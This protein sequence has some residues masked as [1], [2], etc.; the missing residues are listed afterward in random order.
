MFRAMFRG[1]RRGFLPVC[2]FLIL[3]LIPALLFARA[4]GGQGYSGGGGGG[5]SGGGGGSGSGRGDGGGLL[6]IVFELFRLCIAYPAIGIPIVLLIAGFFA[7]AYFKGKAGYQTSVIR[8]ANASGDV[9]RQPAIVTALQQSD[10]A[11]SPDTFLS[12]VTSAFV[13]IQ[14]AWSMQKLDDVRPFLS[15]AV[16]ERFS[17]QFDEQRALG[18]RNLMDRVTITSATLTHAQTD[19]HFDELAVRIVATAI[20]QTIDAKNGRVITGSTS[21]EPFVE[22]WSFLRRRGAKTQPGKPGLMEGQC[23]N[24]GGAIALN[25]SANC[26]YCRALL[27][28]GQYDWVL[29]EITQECEW[30]PS[31]RGDLPGVAALRQRDPEFNPQ[32]MED[33]A[34][35]IFWRRAAAERLQSADPLRKVAFDAFCQHFSEQ[36]KTPRGQPRQY[37]GECAVGSVETLGV[38]L[39]NAGGPTVPQD[40][41]DRALVEVRWSGRQFDVDAQRAIRRGQQGG[42]V[43]TLFVL[44]RKPAARS[45]PDQSISSAHCPN[46][47]APESGGVSGA[48]E[49]CGIIL[50]DGSKT[51]ALE[52][53]IL[54]HDDR[55]DALIDAMQNSAASGGSTSPAEAFPA[56]PPPLSG[57]P[58]IPQL[59]GAAARTV[60]PLTVLS[61]M[62]KMTLADGTIDPRERKMLES[63]ADRFAVP[64]DRL[65][66]LIAAAQLNAL[67][68]PQPASLEEARSQLEAMGR[69]ALADGKLSREEYA[70]LLSTGGEWGLSDYDVKALLRQCKTDL[71]AEA[72]VL[73]RGAKTSRNNRAAH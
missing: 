53:E 9:M 42:V 54:L 41:M 15:D 51:W 65:E 72:K 62:V 73:L 1:R 17:L 37:I 22:I 68:L 47:G 27:R 69:V 56:G 71:F 64:R 4:G 12:R 25:Q 8:R 32:E 61:W 29:A 3:L 24:C 57:P 33:R 55:A 52:E 20:D 66:G 59:R 67:N 11:F 16:G 19:A 35:V 21:A 50:N 30:E 43:H 26:A 70:L 2:V 39:A 18:T 28:S 60:P 63:V 49:F 40:G 45:N 44:A 23:P 14:A 58:P 46:C 34:S 6:W 10:P 36:H 48:C 38:L 7:Y 31:E 5:R 13:R